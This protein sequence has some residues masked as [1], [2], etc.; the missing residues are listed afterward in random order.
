MIT[1]YFSVLM[2]ALLVS[3][4]HL[5]SLSV[6]V[7]KY[8]GLLLGGFYLVIIF[9]KAMMM[10]SSNQYLYSLLEHEIVMIACKRLLSIGLEGSW[11]G[12]KSTCI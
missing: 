12:M 6:N 10:Q 2:R 9:F 3:N 11:V 7:M 8:R 4:R 1:V 5:C